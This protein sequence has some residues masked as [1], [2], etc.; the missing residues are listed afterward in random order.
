MAFVNCL[1][2]R[3]GLE[4]GTIALKVRC[5]C[6]SFIVINDVAAAFPCTCAALSV[7]IQRKRSKR[8]QSGGV[9]HA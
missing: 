8:G 6:A 5:H 1:V 4:P 9:I 7:P 3:P 2:S